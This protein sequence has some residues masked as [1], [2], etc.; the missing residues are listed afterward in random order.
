MEESFQWQWNTSWCCLGILK[1]L[2]Q[3]SLFN[4]SL[5]SKDVGIA[6]PRLRFG[7][8][9]GGPWALLSCS[10]LQKQCLIPSNSS[11]NLHVLIA[12]IHLTAPDFRAQ[13]C[14]LTNLSVLREGPAESCRPPWWHTRSHWTGQ[15]CKAGSKPALISTSPAIIPSQQLPVPPSCIKSTHTCKINSQSRWEKYWSRGKCWEDNAC[16]LQQGWGETV[17]HQMLPQKQIEKLPQPS[18]CLQPLCVLALRESLVLAIF[19]VSST[20]SPAIC[21][22]LL[23]Y[24]HFCTFSPLSTKGCGILPFCVCFIL[25]PLSCF[26]INSQPL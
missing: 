11:S 14:Y 12:P 13:C 25:T 10:S 7:D 22:P 18:A 4:A 3:R 17:A 9:L 6:N 1:Y 15:V 21:L 2:P 19:S 8:G 23:L 20:P 5:P 16:Q 24:S 26:N